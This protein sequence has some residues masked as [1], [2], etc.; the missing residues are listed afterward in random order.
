[1]TTRLGEQRRLRLVQGLLPEPKLGTSGPAK[2]WIECPIPPGHK[3]S[4]GTQRLR[5]KNASIG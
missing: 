4:N 5:V 1:M 2:V 3:H